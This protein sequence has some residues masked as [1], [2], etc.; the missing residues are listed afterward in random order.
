MERK[1]VL[2]Q[3]YTTI[4]NEDERLET[5]HGKVEFITTT[6]Y[7]DSFLNEGDRI[8]EIGAGTGKYSLYYADKGYDVT[9]V[10]LV[11]HNLDILK[12]KI[13]DYMKL[14]A[15]Q[16]DA[17]DLSGFTSDSFDV[18]LVLGPLYH[19]FT[20]ED[21]KQAI[22]EA[23]RVTKPNGLLG[24]AYLT[25]DSIMISYVLK[26]RHFLDEKRAFTDDYR[27]TVDQDEVFRSFRVD[28]FKKMLEQ[29]NVDYLKQVATDGMSHHL[30]EY[31]D[32]LIEEEFKVWVDY[33]LA[34]C[35]REDLMGYSNHMLYLGRK[36]R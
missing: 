11:S 36:R 21:I 24:L 34:T 28:E 29:F 26:K 27:I 5:N 17:L 16:G 33:H 7:I 13:K 1:E 8:L 31:V 18:T 2:K 9:A 4:C 22:S 35:E 32:D 6:K 20:E 30:K 14:T 3:F 10:E 15:L 19:L 12:S 25:D 23:L